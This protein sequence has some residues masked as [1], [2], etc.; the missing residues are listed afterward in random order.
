[1]SGCIGNLPQVRTADIHYAQSGIFTPADIA[2]SRDAIA[3]ECTPNVETMVMQDVDIEALR[4][5]RYK[6]TTTN[7]LDR[8]TD[9]YRVSYGEDG[10]D[11]VV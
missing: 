9:I 4:R 6:G 7:W 2:F 1:M 3:A 11:L 8:R 5:H 10:H